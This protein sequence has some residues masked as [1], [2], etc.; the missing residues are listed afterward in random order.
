MSYSSPP[1]L[2]DR[3]CQVIAATLTLKMSWPTDFQATMDR[4]F[5]WAKFSIDTPSAA[6]LFIDVSFYARLLVYTVGPILIIALLAGPSLCC[7]IC[8]HSKASEVVNLFRSSTLMLTLITLPT[9]QKGLPRHFIMQITHFPLCR[10]HRSLSRPCHSLA[11]TLAQMVDTFAQVC[12]PAPAFLLPD[13]QVLQITELTATHSSTMTTNLLHR[14]PSWS[15]QLAARSPCLCCSTA[16][17]S[18]SWRGRRSS[19]QRRGFSCDFAWQRLHHTELTT[20]IS[21]G[22]ATLVL[23][24]RDITS[25]VYV[26][27][28][29]FFVCNMLACVCTMLA[30]MFNPRM[31]NKLS[32]SFLLHGSMSQGP[33]WAISMFPHTSTHVSFQLACIRCDNAQSG[34]PGGPATEATQ[35]RAK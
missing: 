6:C 26:H 9:V 15:G 7:I 8:R 34:D 12:A 22:R 1:A 28:Q 31:G 35:S 30:R 27:E 5:S 24:W 13:T 19:V 10:C 17:T 14:L 21:E 33:P 32:F 20:V 2:P 18:Q 16:I 11:P 23:L 29:T 4:W 25:Y 3:C